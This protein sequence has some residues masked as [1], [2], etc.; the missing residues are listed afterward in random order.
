MT[1]SKSLCQS[2]LKTHNGQIIG[3]EFVCDDGYRLNNGDDRVE[4][5]CDDTK[6]YEWKCKDGKALPR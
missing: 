6:F 4:V 5:V 2:D 3:N 1:N